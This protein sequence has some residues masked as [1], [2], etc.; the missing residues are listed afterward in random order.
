MSTPVPSTCPQQLLSHTQLRASTQP[1]PWFHHARASPKQLLHQGHI[2]REV[3][4]WKKTPAYS[5]C[6]QSREHPYPHT[7][8]SEGP[9]PPSC[10]TC[11]APQGHHEGGNN[12]VGSSLSMVLTPAPKEGE[13]L[14]SPTSTSTASVR[15]E[16]SHR[17]HPGCA[18]ARFGSGRWHKHRANRDL[19]G[20]GH[21]LPEPGWAEQR[22]G[23]GSRGCCP[24]TG[25]ALRVPAPRPWGRAHGGILLPSSGGHRATGIVS[26]GGPWKEQERAQVGRRAPLGATWSGEKCPCPFQGLELGER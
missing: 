26:H 14:L 25:R 17:P 7:P 4:I 20:V 19:P 22:Q 5:R 12:R 11:T 23:R 13:N 10:S 2:W 9:Q 16:P 8:G 3:H 24:R 18:A 21:P 15:T 1:R 6:S